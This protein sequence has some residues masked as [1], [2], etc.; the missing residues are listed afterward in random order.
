MIS[1]SLFACIA[2]NTVN[3]GCLLPGACL[4]VRALPW[5][6]SSP[7]VSRASAQLMGSVGCPLG[8]LI[9]HH[10]RLEQC[11]IHTPARPWCKGGNVK[12]T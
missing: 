8:Q 1:L 5:S 3:Y 7:G 10:S 4:G 11:D 12:Q 6:C 9:R 2:I